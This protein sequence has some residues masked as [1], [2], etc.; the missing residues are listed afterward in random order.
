MDK[1]KILDALNVIRQIC[2]ESQCMGCPF[3]AE[4][5]DEAGLIHCYLQKAPDVWSIKDD[6]DQGWRAFDD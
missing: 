1:E 2:V 3:R 5:P 4:V 6:S